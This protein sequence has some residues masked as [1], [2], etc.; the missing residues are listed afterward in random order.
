M[1][2]YGTSKKYAIDFRGE[3]QEFDS[4][5]ECEDHFSWVDDLEVHEFDPD[6][7][8]YI[9]RDV[10]EEFQS[11][12]SGVAYDRGHSSGKEEVAMI[13]REMVNDFLPAIHAFEKRLKEQ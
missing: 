10:P 7:A 11:I 3:R 12:M 2:I 4:V 5:Q 8:E 1:K 6:S 9:L 13:L